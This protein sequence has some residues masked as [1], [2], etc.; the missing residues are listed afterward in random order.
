MR[1]SAPLNPADVPSPGAATCRLGFARMHQ[2]LQESAGGDHYGSSA[3]QRR[4]EP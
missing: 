3:I 4:L 2:R 1:A